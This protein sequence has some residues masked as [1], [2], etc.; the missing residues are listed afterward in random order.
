[1]SWLNRKMRR[2]RSGRTENDGNIDIDNGD[3]M[4]MTRGDINIVIDEEMMNVDRGLEVGV[5]IQESKG[6]EESDRIRIVGQSGNEATTLEIT[7]EK[8]VRVESTGSDESNESAV[9]AIVTVDTGIHLI[10]TS[11][12]NNYPPHGFYFMHQTSQRTKSTQ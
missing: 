5:L 4:M 2:L 6:S 8:Q 10:A 9:L 3:G 11:F 1:M 12:V 7:D